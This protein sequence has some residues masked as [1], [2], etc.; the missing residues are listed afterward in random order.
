MNVETL[1]DLRILAAGLVAR[2]DVA[3][4]DHARQE[5]LRAAA[6]TLRTAKPRAALLAVLA[7]GPLKVPEIFERFTLAGRTT[8]EVAIAQMCSRLAKSGALRRV[9]HGRYA[10]A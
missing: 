2:I 6:P 7:S 5:A 9:K 3:L 10:R 8:N 1:Q 4:A